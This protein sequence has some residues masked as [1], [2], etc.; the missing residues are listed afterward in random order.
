MDLILLDS[1]E[2][3]YISYHSKHQKTMWELKRGFESD[4][5]RVWM[6]VGEKKGSTK[7]TI[8]KAV[9]KAAYVLIAMSREYQSSPK[10]RLGL[11]ISI[12]ELKQ[13][14]R[15]QQRQRP[16]MNHLYKNV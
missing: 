15:Q 8:A 5:I 16:D 10:C 3:I 9:G 4:G 11:L 13:R 1:G 7:E 12:A 14:W 2:Y 6:D